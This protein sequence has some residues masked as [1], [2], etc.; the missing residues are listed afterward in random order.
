MAVVLNG[1]RY[2]ENDFK[3]YGYVSKFPSPIFTDMILE[4]GNKILQTVV[5]HEANP[6]IQYKLMVK[7]NAVGDTVFVVEE[8]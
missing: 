5:N 3:G 7:Q 4:I 8:L 1:N 6:N 2:D